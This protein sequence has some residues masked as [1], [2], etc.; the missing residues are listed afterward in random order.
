MIR[1]LCTAKLMIFVVY[2]QG[3]FTM[4]HRSSFICYVSTI[5]EFCVLTLNLKS[6]TVFKTLADKSW[7]RFV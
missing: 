7:S 6:S 4:K 1:K 2:G 3:K 5:W